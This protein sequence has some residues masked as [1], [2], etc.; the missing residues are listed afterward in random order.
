MNNTKEYA[1]IESAK[2]F[3]LWQFCNEHWNQSEPNYLDGDLLYEFGE[4][5][6]GNTYGMVEMK[7]MASDIVDYEK[8]SFIEFLRAKKESDYESNFQPSY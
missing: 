8:S 3:E 1:A 7:Q 4:M 2:C 5:P 6:T